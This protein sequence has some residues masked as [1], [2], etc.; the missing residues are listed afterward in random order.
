[1]R[2]SKPEPIRE[3]EL[4]DEPS[5]EP[6]PLFPQARPDPDLEATRPRPD[7]TEPQPPFP[8]P[9]PKLD[10]RALSIALDIL[11]FR[12]ILLLCCVASAGLFF[13]AAMWPD[14]WR[15][16]A[17]AAFSVI[18]TLPCLVFYRKVE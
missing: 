15:L 14:E 2:Q 9:K 16:G 18:V 12:L 8:G 11:S 13:M 17:A 10:A 6:V 7:P 1:M 5:V 3:D 4:Y